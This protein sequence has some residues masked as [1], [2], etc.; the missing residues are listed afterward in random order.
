MTK[1]KDFK[2]LCLLVIFIA[3]NAS[4]KVETVLGTPLAKNANLSGTLPVSSSESEIILSRDEFVISYNK[5]RRSPNWV[6]WKLDASSLGKT[7]RQD[8]F[9]RDSELEKYLQ[10]TGKQYHAVEPSEYDQSCFDRGHQSPS[11]DHSSDP[12]VNKASFVMTNIVPQTPYLNRVIWE[13][14]EQHT[15]NLVL[16]ENKKVYIIT[17]PIYDEDFGSIGPKKDIPVPSKNFKIIVVLDAKQ[18]WKNIDQQTEIISVIMPNVDLDGSK[19]IVGGPCK[20]FTISKEDTSDWK[21]YV[22]SVPEIQRLSGLAIFSK[23]P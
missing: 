5:V 9:A 18:T 12:A 21:N 14:L 3:I 6:A 10:A 11:A 22:S 1:L 13:H 15:R 4:A 16:N 8:A 2:L 20:Q 17:G 19:P 7:P 23:L